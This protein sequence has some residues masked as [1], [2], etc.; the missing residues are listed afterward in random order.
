MQ[1]RAPTSSMPAP[2]TRSRP[3]RRSR[4]CRPTRY[5]GNG[6]DQ[7]HRQRVR[8]HPL[9]Q[10]RRQRARRRR[11][12]R[13]HGRL[14]R[15]RHLLRRQCRRPGD[16]K[17]G[18]GQRPWST[19][20]SATRSTPALRSRCS[21][22]PT[23]AGTA[24]IN[25]TGNEF[26]NTIYGNA[27]ANILDGGGGADAHD[28][29]RRQRHLFRRQCRR[30]GDRGRRRRHR[31][32][33]TR[34]S[35]TRSRRARRSRCSRPT[36]NAGTGAINLTGNELANTIYGNAGANL[37]E[38]R[39][40]RRTSW[41][42]S[43]ATTST[44]S[45]MP[46][47]G[48]SKAPAAAPTSSTP[49]SATR[50]R[51]GS[52]VEMLSTT[53]QA[54]DRGDQ[55]RPATSSPT[56][57]TAMPAPTRST[58]AAGADV[59][60]G[61]GGNDF[62]YRRQCRRPGDRERRASGTDGVYASVSYTLRGRLVDRD[63]ADHGSTWRHRRRSTS[64]ATSS[65]TRS[66]AMPAPTCSTA[67]AARTLL[68]GLGGAD[69]FAFT[70]ALGGGNVDTIADFVVGHRQDRAR[71]CGVRR[72][73][74]PARSTPMRSSSARPRRDADDRIIYNQ[75]TGAAL[76]RRR[77]QRRRRRGPVR[78]RCRRTELIAASDFTVI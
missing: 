3:A 42:A 43:A 51:P 26:A 6:G 74:P 19:P 22:P 56:R 35:A 50:S 29:L 55:P 68:I 1:A 20:A 57:S 53:S 7:P 24:A 31:P 65:P 60:V 36:A 9:R 11:R 32:S 37:L 12:R 61:F 25:L 5:G 63:P 48:R 39:R 13:H 15:Q 71:R 47:T 16:R 62:Y 40:R 72:A 69:S 75:A 18:R 33:S 10:C 76:L 27:G 41:S 70:T 4:F 38:R 58:A 73:R 78:H 66:T 77:R 21:R 28:R 59:M 23:L 2:A 30:P 46:A 34:A 64:P 54:G 49:A 44:S 14:R 52:E 17:R 67:A 45:T 8:Q